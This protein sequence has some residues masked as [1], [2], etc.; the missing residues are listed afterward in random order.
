MLK[1]ELKPHQP[2]PAEKVDL[3]RLWFQPDRAFLTAGIGYDP[4]NRLLYI[5]QLRG[6]RD[7]S[8]YEA[9]PA[10]HVWRVK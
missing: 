3:T 6:E 10:I 2:R 4:V 5:A 9:V 7:S 1:G 8:R